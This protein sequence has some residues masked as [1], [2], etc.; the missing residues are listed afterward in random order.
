MKRITIF[1]IF[2]MIVFS[3]SP[4][5]SETATAMATGHMTAGGVFSIEWYCD[6]TNVLYDTYIPFSNIPAVPVGG[7]W[8][9]Y[10]DGRSEGDNKSDTGI[11]CRTSAGQTWYLKIKGASSTFPLEHFKFFLGQ[12]YNRNTGQPSNGLLTYTDGQWHNT[13]TAFFTVYTAG[14]QDKSNLPLGTI[15]TFSFAIEIYPGMVA[16][17]QHTITI[18]YTVTTSV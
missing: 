14:S 5:F 18:Q 7:K 6:G 11:I 10:A 17:S 4:A 9:V 16:G 13:P 15:A 3:S 1:F 12:P 8:F 2:G